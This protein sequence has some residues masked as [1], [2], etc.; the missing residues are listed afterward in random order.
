MHGSNICIK[1]KGLGQSLIHIVAHSAEPVPSYPCP[2]N[3][4][5][6]MGCSS[7]PKRP[8]LFIPLFMLVSLSS[9]WSPQGPW[10]WTV[11]VLFVTVFPGPRMASDW[12]STSSPP[13][14]EHGV[15]AP[16]LQWLP[17]L[18]MNSGNH[19]SRSG[20]A[21]TPQTCTACFRH[22]QPASEVPVRG[23]VR[24]LDLHFDF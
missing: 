2:R 10:A 24:E 3:G 9:V 11:S 16:S 22:T 21:W 6:P 7:Q 4:L 5:G 17:D 13:G 23:T 14:N 19:W 1:E 12:F 18:R 20:S 8:F 15:R